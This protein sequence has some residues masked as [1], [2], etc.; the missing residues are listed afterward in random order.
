MKRSYRRLKLACYSVNVTM[1][2]MGNMPPLLFI[3]FRQ[4]YGISYTLLGLLVLVNFSTQLAVDLIF[5]FFSHRFNIKKTIKLTPLIA[6]SGL[7]LFALAPVIFKDHIYIGL[8]LG[9]IVFSSASGLAE[10]LISP[11]IAA[12][13]SNDPDREMSKLHSVYAWGV[14]PVVVI[15]TLFLLTFGNTYWQILVF[16]FTSVPLFSFILYTGVDIPEMDTPKKVSGALTYFKDK[17]LWLC[18]CAI[19]LGGASECTMGLWASSYI[20]QALLIPKVW[21]DM[22]GVALFALTLG[23]GRTMYAKVGKNIYKVLFLGA[24]GATL[25]YFVSAVTPFSALGLVACGLTGI[26]VSM[27]WPGSLI[28]ASEKFPTGGVFIYAMMASGGDLGASVGPQLV[29]VITDNVMASETMCAFAQTL[30]LSVEQFGMKIGMLVGMLFPFAAVFL[31]LYL[32]KSKKE[33]KHEN[34]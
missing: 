24:C 20:E 1:A 30:S 32:L 23:I 22:L 3:T 29:G 21:G 27:M 13:P 5:S 17:T 25:C 14:V 8:V 9:T 28:V 10:V 12:I 11:V 15:S 7:C 16:A 26:C 2:I 4:L 34:I 18:V 19:F 6:F 33:N 31:Y